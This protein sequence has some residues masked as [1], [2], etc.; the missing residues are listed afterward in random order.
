MGFYSLG[1]VGPSAWSLPVTTSKVS[2]N[3]Q[4]KIKLEGS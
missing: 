4:S 3:H 1:L 2:M